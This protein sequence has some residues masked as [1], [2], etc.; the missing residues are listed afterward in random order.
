MGNKAGLAYE[1]G[2][3]IHTAE[4]AWVHGPL[5]AG[6]SDLD[7]FRDKLKELIQTLNSNLTVKKRVSSVALCY[8]CYCQLNNYLITKLCH[9]SI[10]IIADKGYSGEPDLISTCN[11]IDDLEV[12]RFKNRVLSRQ[13]SFNSLL[14]NFACLNTKYCHGVKS[15][16]I[17]FQACCVVN[18][19]DIKLGYK[20]LMDAYH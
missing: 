9:L 11:E 10:K 17:S 13:E 19:Y 4:L 8:Y 5:P 2:L 7:I 16:G 1:V 20:S 14:K 12:K 3:H 15:H 18:H 6:T